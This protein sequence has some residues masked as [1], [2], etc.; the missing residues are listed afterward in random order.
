[1]H[2][3]A[4]DLVEVRTRRFTKKKKEVRTRRAG[5]AGGLSHVVHG[6]PSSLV[7]RL[8]ESGRQAVPRML[9]LLSR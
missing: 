8:A 9:H 6:T 4:G 5:F 2:P 7:L 3:A 1:M